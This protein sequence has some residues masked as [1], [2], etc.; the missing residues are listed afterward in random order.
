VAEWHEL[1][2]DYRIGRA[3]FVSLPRPLY[4][5]K[6]PDGPVPNGR[7]VQAIR[8]AISRLGSEVRGYALVQYL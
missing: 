7:D 8:R 2:Y 1:G 3:K 6:D 5:P 4:P